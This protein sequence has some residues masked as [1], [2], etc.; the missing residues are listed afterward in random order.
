MLPC[1]HVLPLM[2]GTLDQ[3]EKVIFGI[4]KLLVMVC[5]KA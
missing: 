3:L 2:W 1:P 4:G 5:Q